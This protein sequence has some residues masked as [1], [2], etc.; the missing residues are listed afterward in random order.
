MSEFLKLICVLPLLFCANEQAD[1]LRLDSKIKDGTSV[2]F[3]K[4]SG[5][6]KYDNYLT[7]NLP[8]EPISDIFQ[9]VQSVEGV[10]LKSR[11]EAH[12]TV[13]TPLE[14]WNILKPLSI[15]MVEIDQIAQSL[16]IQD[17]Q[18]EI[19]CLGMGKAI[20]GDKEQK[21][22]FVVVQ[23]E[24]LMDIRREIQ[25]LVI[26]K[27]GA[28]TD[29]DPAHF[30]PHITVGYTEDDLHESHGVI[31]DIRSCIYPIKSE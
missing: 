26:A 4:F 12:I 8:F 9:Q 6:G 1:P 18:F 5:P 25:R 13:V 7:M 3:L 14:Y 10:I 21:T 23:S 22:F 20:L 31:K 16:R 15:T 2:E 30:Y 17:S 24:D 27:G 11:G 28:A 19:L 29:F